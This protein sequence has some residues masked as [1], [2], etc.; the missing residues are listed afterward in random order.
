MPLFGCECASS[1][2][3][4]VVSN[5]WRCVGVFRAFVHACVAMR[6]E[7]GERCVCQRVHM[8]VCVRA[9]VRARVVARVTHVGTDGLELVA[10][11]GEEILVEHF[12]HVPEDDWVRHL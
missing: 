8:C 9:C 12:D 3:A 5:A 2:C 11:L 4:R 6:G 1:A 7:A 10:I